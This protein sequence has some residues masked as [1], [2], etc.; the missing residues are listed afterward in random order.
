MSP[1]DHA[2]NRRFPFGADEDPR[3]DLEFQTIPGLIDY[4][5]RAYRE[6]LAIVCGLDDPG[7]PKRLTFAGL[8]DEVARVGRGLIA[9]GVQPG[10]S[11]A[12]WAPNCME[13][14]LT[15][16]A[17]T[18][19]GGVVVTLNTRFKGAEAA[20]ILRTAKVRTLCTVEGFL[21][22]DYPAMLVGEDLGEL[23]SIVAMKG[24]PAT[25]PEGT[26]VTSFDALADRGRSVTEEEYEARRAAVHP[27]STADLIFTSGTT[28]NPKGVATSHAQ[29]LRTF[30]T[31]STIVGLRH[32][33][34]YLIVNPFFHTFGY[35]SG[36]LAS[37]MAG[38]TIYPEPVFDLEIVGRHLQS[39]AITVLP[40]PPTLFQSLLAGP[41]PVAVMGSLRLV[42]TGAAVVPVELVVELRDR[43]GAET[44]L[45]AYGLTESCGVVTMCRRGDAPDVIA[46]TSGRAIPDVEVRCVDAQGN[47]VAPGEAGEIIVRGYN[48]MQGYF[49]N[50][51]ATAETI[52]ENG[53]LHTGD[54][55][56]MDDAGNVI[57][58]D[59]LKD[60]YVVGGFNAYPAEIEAVLRRHPMVAQV[61]VVGVADD[62]MGEVGCAYVVPTGAPSDEVGRELLAWSKAQMA[63]YKVPRYLVWTDALPLNA[64]GKVLKRELRSWFHAG[65]DPVVSN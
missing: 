11:V 22:F 48:V 46:T 19:I 36:L 17:I 2:Q 37:L 62:R 25:L 33:D 59:R 52:D 49:A 38:A 57:I 18:S 8:A 50:E 39:E 44:V 56:I 27:D 7:G 24:S 41:D 35:K 23:S 34:R 45:T 28:G 53:F 16:L 12:I 58:T 64:S 40:G 32:G 1:L 47:D 29:T 60:M 4:A 55:A 3:A 5:A 61:A 10:E 21:G 6:D 54:V 14:A 20:Y 63:N 9:L 65:R 13:W 31:W 26:T 42:V 51:A 30:G 43:I 15:A